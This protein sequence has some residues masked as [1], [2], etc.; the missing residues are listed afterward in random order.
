MKPI[1]MNITSAVPVAFSS[2]VG[3]SVML[4][5]KD[6]AVIGLLAITGLPTT[7]DYKTEAQKIARQIADHFSAPQ[8][9]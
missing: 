3:Q 8:K 1:D 7:V 4:H 9:P 5:N 2:T 6:G